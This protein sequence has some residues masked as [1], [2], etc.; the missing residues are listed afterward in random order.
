M[1]TLEKNFDRI[2]KLRAH[3]SSVFQTQVSYS[4]QQCLTPER[5]KNAWLADTLS[6][7]PG[8]ADSNEL[9]R[10]V[11]AA[12]FAVL[13]ETVAP[14]VF[15]I[16][17]LFDEAPADSL[18]LEKDFEILAAPVF[19]LAAS[20][21]FSRLWQQ[22]NPWTASRYPEVADGIAMTMRDLPGIPEHSVEL[23]H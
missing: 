8:W 12:P 1:N 22:Q 6:T 23:L 14:A 16:R 21:E 2:A 18:R 17:I 13:P 3:E 10:Y 9:L 5:D 19:Q 4:V 11:I 20:G 15:A 7:R